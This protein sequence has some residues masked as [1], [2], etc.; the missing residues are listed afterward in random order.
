MFGARAAR[1]ALDDASA[2]IGAGAPDPIP[3]QRPPKLTESSRD[4]LW[5]HGGLVRD[6]EGLKLL[7]ADPYP[8]VRLIAACALA[9]TESRGAHQ[10]TDHPDRDSAFDH[11]HVTIAADA[12][13]TPELWH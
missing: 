8:L 3:S 10:R 7:A 6:G 11:R 13:Q 5:R 2:Q 4:Q 1:A 9:R 12:A